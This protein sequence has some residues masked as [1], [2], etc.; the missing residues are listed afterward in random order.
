MNLIKAVK[1]AKINPKM[2]EMMANGMVYC[3][4]AEIIS[5]NDVMMMCHMK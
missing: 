5:G 4:I 1:T 3:N 2:N